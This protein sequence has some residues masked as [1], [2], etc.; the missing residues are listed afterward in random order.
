MADAINKAHTMASLFQDL[1]FIYNMRQGDI[2]QVIS[3]IR[4]HVIMLLNTL[5]ELN[6]N[7][8]AFMS[9]LSDED[10]DD[11]GDYLVY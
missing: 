11:D 1:A 8:P 5:V 7:D 9:E 6:I 2:F 10:M 3:A 4:P